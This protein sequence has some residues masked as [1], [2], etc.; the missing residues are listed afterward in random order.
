[1]A[2][3]SVK[4]VGYFMLPQILT[5]GLTTATLPSLSG[6]FSLMQPAR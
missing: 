5:G 4:A 3:G 1:M 2:D 6:G